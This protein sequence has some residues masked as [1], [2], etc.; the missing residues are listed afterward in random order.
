MCSRRERSPRFLKK[1]ARL[2]SPHDFYKVPE[3]GKSPR[4]LKSSRG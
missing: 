3:V 1:F 4:F 2:K